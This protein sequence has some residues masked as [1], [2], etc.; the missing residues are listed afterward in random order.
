M[1]VCIYMHTHTLYIKRQI[2][3][4]IRILYIEKYTCMCVY[5]NIN[6]YIFRIYIFINTHTHTYIHGD[7]PED[8]LNF[9]EMLPLL[10]SGRFQKTIF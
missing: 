8:L 2:Y 1:N 10:W 4:S 9:P 3:L 7:V 6:I 5:I